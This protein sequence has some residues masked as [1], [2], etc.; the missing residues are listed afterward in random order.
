MLLQTGY[1]TELQEMRQAEV[2]ATKIW[3]QTLS[4]TEALNK[5]K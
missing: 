2:N 4:K 5:Q 3:D 1:H